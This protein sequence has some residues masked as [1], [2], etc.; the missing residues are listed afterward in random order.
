[1]N[2]LKTKYYN[3]R[4]ES[5]AVRRIH[6]GKAEILRMIYGAVRD[7]NW[8]TLNSEIVHE[9][10]FQGK[11]RFQV[12]ADIAYRKGDIHFEAHYTIKG[13]GALFEFTMEGEAKSTFLTNRTGFC[14]LHP[15]KECSGKSCLIYHPDET[16]EKAVFPEQISP[17]QPM[18][19]VSGM[20][21]RPTKNLTAKLRFAGEVFEM[22]DQRNWTDASYKTY[23]RPLD[24][25]FPFEI[26]KGEKIWQK[27]EMNI[28]KILQDEVSTEH[29]SF[30]IDKKKVYPVPETG[31]CTT[32][33]EQPVEQSEVQLLRH[34]PLNHLRA[35]VKLFGKGWEAT[36][37]KAIEEAGLLDLPLFLVLYFSHNFYNELLK[38]SKKLPGV[39][40]PIKYI[41]IVG[42]DHL[43][44]SS[45]VGAVFPTL[46]KL[47]PDVKIG[48][49]V[50]AYF[51]ELNRNR[52]K[53]KS[54]LTDFISFTVCPQV[55]AFD[56]MTIVENL[57][58]LKYAVESA[59]QIFPGKP[60][61]ISPLTLKQRFNVVATS[62]EPE[63]VG[64]ELPPQVDERQNTLFTAQW[65]LVSIKF[66]AQSGVKCASFFETV[67]WRGF[68]QGN[69]DP[70][71]PEKFSA[72]N[73]DIFP[74]FRLVEKMAGFKKIIHSES[75]N[76]LEIEGVVFLNDDNDNFSEK[77][78]LSNFH[79]TPRAIIIKGL[80]RFKR[81]FDFSTHEEIKTEKNKITVPAQSIVILE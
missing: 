62:G 38:F 25:P 74:V 7:R 10:I 23:C 65:L 22:E 52:N 48:A 44:D 67:G 56:K 34:L 66:L 64:G 11:N 63:P 61:F 68:I 57:E 46:K 75:S 24:M 12:D 59:I 51:A 81:I 20:Q 69:Y 39:T 35:E 79:E 2:L 21:W 14:V 1:M 36:L 6:S 72:R 9:K 42:K 17:H 4:Y 43:S 71:L 73:G 30:N 60:V 8:G 18:K 58:G 55:H 54:D 80:K 47:L 16:S 5:G 27:I 33:R 31:T 53:I 49:G 29:I 19:N 40:T 26:K 41:L 32:S 37:K 45:L 28:E 70:P 78:F 3:L 76:P 77:I 15:V 50:N 13:T